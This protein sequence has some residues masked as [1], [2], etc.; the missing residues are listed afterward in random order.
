MHKQVYQNGLSK[1]VFISHRKYLIKSYL[2]SSRMKRSMQKC[3]NV[4]MGLKRFMIIFDIKTDFGNHVNY[5][6]FI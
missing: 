3:L 1:L 2:K 5:C 6:Q 4:T